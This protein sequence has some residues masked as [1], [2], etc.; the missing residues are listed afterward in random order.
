MKCS[1][2]HQPECVSSPVLEVEVA[3]LILDQDVAGAEVH[4]TLLKDIAEDLL[5]C[6]LGVF[7]SVEV[8]D[9]VTLD[10]LPYELSWLP[11]LCLD[12]VSALISDWVPSC[13]VNLCDVIDRIGFM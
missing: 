4:V 13:F 5:L 3:K 7:V 8:F 2:A 11:R 12:A 9:W 6:G 10:Y 1:L